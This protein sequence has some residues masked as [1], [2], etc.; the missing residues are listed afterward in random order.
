MFHCSKDGISIQRGVSFCLS[1]P[2]AA[3]GESIG[4]GRRS[5]IS[6]FKRAGGGMGVHGYHRVTAGFS[7]AL[8][9]CGDG[10]GIQIKH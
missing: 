2:R 8:T 5:G 9:I 6:V 3:G 10:R 4:H 7:V 1:P